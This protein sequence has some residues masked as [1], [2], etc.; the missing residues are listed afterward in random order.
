MKYLDIA[1]SVKNAPKLD[2]GFVP[3]GV[4]RKA[5]L[6]GAAVPFSVAAASLPESR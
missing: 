3:L 1:Y 4:W 6:D 5:F 2:P